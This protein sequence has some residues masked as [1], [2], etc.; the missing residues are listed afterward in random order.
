VRSWRFSGMRLRTSVC[1]RMLR[2]SVCGRVWM[3]RTSVCARRWCNCWYRMAHSVHVTY[4]TITVRMTHLK[5]VFSIP[6]QRARCKIHV[7]YSHQL[8]A[9]Y[10]HKSNQISFAPISPDW[11]SAAAIHCNINASV[12][13]R[14]NFSTYF[15][16]FTLQWCYSFQLSATIIFDCNLTLR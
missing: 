3:L 5:A 8:C 15:H 11:T 1:G 9:I 13:L 12:I 4:T 6:T 10:K 16:N 2:T 14:I 7:Y